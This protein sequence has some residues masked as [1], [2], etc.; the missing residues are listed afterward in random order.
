ML[1]AKTHAR[2]GDLGAPKVWD[3]IYHGHRNGLLS[4]MELRM[5]HAALENDVSGFLKCYDPTRADVR[6]QDRS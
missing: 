4:E 2:L 3:A 1:L 5:A 6:S